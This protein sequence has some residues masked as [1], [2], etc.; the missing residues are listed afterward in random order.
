VALTLKD[1]LLFNTDFDDF[2]DDEQQDAHP[3]EREKDDDEEVE[4]VAREK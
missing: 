1:D 2:E 4:D 3:Q